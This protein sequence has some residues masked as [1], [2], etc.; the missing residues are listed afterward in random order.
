[1]QTAPQGAVLRLLAGMRALVP[2]MMLK[3]EVSVSER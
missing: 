2:L 1:M 3:T